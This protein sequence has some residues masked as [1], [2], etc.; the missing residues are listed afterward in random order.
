MDKRE[1]AS[2][3]MAIRTYYPKEQILPNEAAMELWY[4]EVQDIPADVATVALRKWVSTN[5]WSPTIADIRELSANI[6]YG[7]AMTWGESWERAVAA[8][9]K[10]GSYNQKA[11]MES[12]DPL[13]RK[14]VQ[15]LGYREL[16]ISEN[17]MQDRANFR[18][19]FETYQKREEQNRQI[20]TPLLE[21]ISN[22]QLKGIDGKPLQIGAGEEK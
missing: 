16:C 12:L 17:P 21:V 20:A 7:D 22:L 5:K 4:R 2:F 18:M 3:A 14:V 10:Y 15:N 13:T 9:R 8:I 19:V 11:A 6:Q 1:F